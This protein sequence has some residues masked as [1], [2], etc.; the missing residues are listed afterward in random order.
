MMR[1]AIARVD[2]GVSIM[3]MD[4]GGDPVVEILKWEALGLKA[5]SWRII[6]A[7]DIP[8][9]RTF[10]V[11]LMDNG[12]QLT[13]D[14]LKARDVWRNKMRAARAPLLADLDV[15][16]MRAQER[17][18]PTQAIVDRKQALRD[19]TADPAI[20]AAQTPDELR[21]AWPAILSG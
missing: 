15:Q 2:G 7:V 13:Y 18:E 20:E 19:V 21:K 11:A 5:A 12:A 17:G 6:G 9:D 10:R 14:M 4:D 8:T 1:I 16:F 3:D